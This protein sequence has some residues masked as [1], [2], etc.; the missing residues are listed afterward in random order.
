MDAIHLR[1]HSS[2]ELMPFPIELNLPKKHNDHSFEGIAANVMLL[3]KLIHDHNHESAKSNDDRRKQRLA[4]MISILDDVKF[5]MQ[6]SQGTGARKAEFRRCNSELRPRMHGNVPLPRVKKTSEPGSLAL[7]DVDDIE[8]MRK[9][10]NASLAARKSLEMMCSS[11]GREKEFMSTELLK[12]VHELSELEELVEDL[13]AQNETLLAKVRAC[14]TEHKERRILGN[15]L[16]GEPLDNALLHER[17]K[18]LSKKLLKSLDGY[19]SMKRKYKDSHDKAVHLRKTMDELE[20]DLARGRAC[21]D[22]LRQIVGVKNG[23]SEDGLEELDKLE[24]LFENLES[25]SSDHHKWRTET[26]CKG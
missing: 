16:G 2:P 4:G 25:K 12:K 17:N 23:Q 18:E 8:Q 11:L 19:R 22:G 6:K 10:L 9:E 26:D 7:A 1:A 13:K 14:A 15:N 20:E 24:C 21:V 5:R 3:L